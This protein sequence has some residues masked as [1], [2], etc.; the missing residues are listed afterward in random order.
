M[1]GELVITESILR[2]RF[3]GERDLVTYELYRV[4]DHIVRC[5]NCH[6]VVK[7]EF[8]VSGCPLCG[9]SPFNP[10]PVLQAPAV[11]PVQSTWRSQ[12]SFM[13]LLIL[14]SMLALLPFAFPGAADF[15]YKATFEM[16]TGLG[17]LL[18]GC[19]SFVAAM[20]VY[21]NQRSRAAWQRSE[22]GGFLLLVPV[23]APYLALAVIWLILFVFSVLVIIISLLLVG[24]ILSLGE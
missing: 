16:D 13:W 2:D 1:R 24:A 17:L 19:I 8:V 23:T 7:T 6:A 14:S 10:S 11:V 4:G 9:S 3:Q 22:Y 5:G 18:I 12:T 15:L 20:I 21:Y